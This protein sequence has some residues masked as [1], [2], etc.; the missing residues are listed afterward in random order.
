MSKFKASGCVRFN[1]AFQQ[2][3]IPA[4][5]IGALLLTATPAF[6]HHAMGG[7]MP[8]NFFQGFLSGVAHP[9]IGP[10][11]FAFIVAVGLFAAVKRQGLLI[12]IAFVLSAMLGTGAHL[13]KVNI[14]GIELFVSG[15]ILL[16]GIL[17][18]MK[19]SPTTPLVAGLSAIAGLFHGY[20]YGEAIFGAE[21]T[22]F[23]AYLAGFTCIQLVVSLSAFW[24]GKTVVL[25]RDTKQQS[26]AKF[27]SAGLVISGV[28]LAF[29]VSQVVAVLLPASPA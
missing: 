13:A 18:A 15:S 6:A 8:S 5:P 25:N 20:A 11:H 19:N 23:L 3:R 26:A 7:K 22:P 14:P 12:P 4:I 21:M 16:F 27:R 28:G 9:L 10:D 2:A 29:F 1:K 24:I 17:L